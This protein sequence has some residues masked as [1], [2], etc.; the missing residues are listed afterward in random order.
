MAGATALQEHS[1][2]TDTVHRACACGGSG[3]DCSCAEATEEHREEP[4]GTLSRQVGQAGRAAHRDDLQAGVRAALAS[5]AIALPRAM[6]ADA[7][8][9]LGADFDAVRVH[10]G[11][12]ARNSARS[13]AALAYTSGTH[14]VLGGDQSMLVGDPGRELLLH[15]LTHV[16]QQAEGAIPRSSAGGGLRVSDPSDAHEQEAERVARAGFRRPPDTSL[17]FVGGSSEHPASV[18]QVQRLVG[19]LSCTAGT[20]SAP[21]DP[22]TL[23]SAIDAEAMAMAQ[24]LATAYGADTAAAA[25]GGPAAPSASLQAYQT[26]FGLP[27]ASAG[28]A[29]NRITGQVRPSQQIALREELQIVSRRFA[30]VARLFSQNLRYSCGAGRIDLAGGCADDCATNNGDAFTCRESSGI[31]LCPSFWTGHPSNT[32]R[33]AILIHEAFHMIWGPNS[34][35]G[36]GEIGDETLT[37]AG[38]NFDVA[39]CWEALVD[40]IFAV[41][42]G[43][44]CP[45]IP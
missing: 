36:Q 11:L 44:S 13:L 37:G 5:P 42:S 2:G 21:P 45:A 43:A 14:I 30:L 25:G 16:V 4:T 31:G 34:P 29:L 3:A 27:P 12:A 38:R 18:P 6:R 23:L 35:R 9:R 20:A 10:A 8:T 41:D 17:A 24:Q 33:A 40:D 15:E 28:G 39:G 32:A 7:E 22:R 1:A 26:H 19:A